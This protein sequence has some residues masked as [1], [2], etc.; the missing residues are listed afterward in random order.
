[1]RFQI[2]QKC[3]LLLLLLYSI[4]SSKLEQIRQ[5]HSSKVD[6]IESK[7]FET[8]LTGFFDFLISFNF[9][10]FK[11]NFDAYRSYMTEKLFRNNAAADQFFIEKNPFVYPPCLVSEN[12]FS[13]LELSGSFLDEF[14]NEI[15][16]RMERNEEIDLLAIERVA[17]RR[18]ER[19]TSS[20]FINGFQSQMNQFL[21]NPFNYCT[22]ALSASFSNIVAFGVNYSGK[23]TAVQSWAATLRIMLNNLVACEL[24]NYIGVSDSVAKGEA[25]V[26]FELVISILKQSFQFLQ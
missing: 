5:S 23:L 8:E 21:T 7:R 19:Q 12:G 10:F 17:L 18:V 14:H 13:H 24:L 6:N 22:G 11:D 1:M 15:K 9:L 4:S 2:L 20:D 25:K 3:L 16:A 26:F